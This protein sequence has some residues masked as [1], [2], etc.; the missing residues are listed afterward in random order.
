M[1]TDGGLAPDEINERLCAEIESQIWGQGFEAP[2]FANEFTVLGQTLLKDAH[3]KLAVMLGRQRFD[4][5][6]FRRREPLTQIS[7]LAYRPSINE[8]RG[9]RSVQLV[10]EA[11]ESPEPH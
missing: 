10:V 11:A 8:F 5:I 9:R 1:L 3:L 6:F 4:A 7:K 2:L